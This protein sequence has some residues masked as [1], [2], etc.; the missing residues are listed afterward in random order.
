M[1]R[2]R[3]TRVSPMRIAPWASSRRGTGMGSKLAMIVCSLWCVQPYYTRGHADDR[4]ALQARS[5][6]PR[7]GEPDDELA[8]PAGPVAVGLD[9]AAVELGEPADQGQADAQAALGALQRAVPL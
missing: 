1:T 6:A 5:L 9:R 3:R 2:S 4:M 8:P 7:R